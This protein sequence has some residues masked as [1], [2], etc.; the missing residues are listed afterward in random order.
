MQRCRG[1]A[2]RGGAMQGWWVHAVLGGGMQGGEGACSA[3]RGHAGVVGPCN[4]WRGHAGGE[5][6]CRSVGGMQGW[7]A[8]V[9]Q[10]R[11]VWQQENSPKRIW[12]IHN[13]QKQNKTYLPHPQQPKTEEMVDGTS[14]TAKT[15]QKVSG[16]SS[17]AKKKA[18]RTKLY[19]GN[20]Q[21]PKNVYGS[22][23]KAKHACI[24]ASIA[25]KHGRGRMGGT[26]S[27][28]VNF[29]RLSI[30]HSIHTVQIHELSVV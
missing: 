25:S 19:L 24:A 10:N 4:A 26:D 30:P 15:K 3:W 17:T 23:S 8:Y 5:G 18:N 7:H 28:R 13:N 12:L 29:V 22:S 16:A 2:A 9:G 1:H 21:Q 27:R 14:S 20:P 11:L 6:A